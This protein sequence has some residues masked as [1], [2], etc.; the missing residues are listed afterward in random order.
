MNP[1]I[2]FALDALEDY[3]DDLRQAH[4]DLY[5]SEKFVSASDVGR[6]Q[7]RIRIAIDILRSTQRD[8]VALE[9]P[10]DGQMAS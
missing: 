8:V 5:F 9:M 6:R 10:S 7:E 2:S 4:N 3:C 1:Y